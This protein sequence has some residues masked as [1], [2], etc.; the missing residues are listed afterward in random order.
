RGVGAGGREGERPERGAGREVRRTVSLPEP[1]GILRPPD[2]A[3]TGDQDVRPAGI[4]DERR[5]GGRSC[6]VEA[7]PGRWEHQTAVRGLVDGKV[8]RRAVEDVVRVPIRSFDGRVG[9]I[10][11][12]DSPPR[13]AAGEFTGARVLHPTQNE[14]G[15]GWMKGNAWVEHVGLEV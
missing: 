6:G 11:S 7:G 14:G 8:L 1:R 10:A 9:A 13:Q 12:A 2:A 15:I 5:D 3:R 4:D